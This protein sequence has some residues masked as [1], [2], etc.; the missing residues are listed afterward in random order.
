MASKQSIT[1]SEKGKRVVDADGNKI[2][3]V[4]G[5][6]GGTAFVDPDPGLTD[7]IMSKL[8]W[9]NVAEDDYPLDESRIEMITDDEI[10]LRRN[11]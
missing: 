2:G 8:G 9:E 10:H 6:R 4:T 7:T 5:V 11:L 1:E 3:I